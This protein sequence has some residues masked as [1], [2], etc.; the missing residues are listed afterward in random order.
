MITYNTI[1]SKV[2]CFNTKLNSGNQSYTGT[3]NTESRLFI[4]RSSIEIQNWRRSKEARN[5]FWTNI[6]VA[7]GQLQLPQL[8]YPFEIQRNLFEIE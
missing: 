3:R 8:S 2:S 4:F 6:V 7:C 5:K 1:I